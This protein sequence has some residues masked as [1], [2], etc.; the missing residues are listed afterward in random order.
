MKTFK[1]LSALLSYPEPELFGQADAFAATLAEEGLLPA[2][3]R[4][5]LDAFIA[6]FMRQDPLEVQE[7]YVSL[8]DRNRSLSLHLYEHIHGESRD[9]GQA[10]VKLGEIYRLH[11]VEIAAHE[12]PD[13]LPLFLEFL[14][15]LP[16]KAA[17]SLLA[18]A[19]HVVAGLRE[20]LA[21]RGS[22]YAAVMSAVEALAAKPAQR[23]AIDEILAMLKPEADS[24]EALD[25]QWEEEAVRFTAADD[26]NTAASAASCGR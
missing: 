13:Y 24:L 23:A 16:H 17:A 3:D 8:F 4:R 20:R 6:D 11:G 19:V 7:R 10:M 14:S 1:L 21:A 26:P 25:R 9:R 18:D 2:R 12:L 5:A 15:L 22:P